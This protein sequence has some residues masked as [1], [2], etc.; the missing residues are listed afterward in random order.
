MLKPEAVA[1]IGP[2]ADAVQTVTS[3]P[4]LEWEKDPQAASYQVRVIDALGQVRMDDFVT[5]TSPATY[6]IPYTGTLTVGM[7]Y[8]F[9]VLSWDELPPLPAT[10][11]IR[12]ASE[13][14]RGVFVYQP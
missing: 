8:Q 3:A 12:A 4:N 14:L 9:R 5:E 6:S 10:A 13:D 1:V 11:A 7:F 2:G